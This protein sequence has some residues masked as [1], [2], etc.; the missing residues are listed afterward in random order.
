MNPETSTDPS[1]PPPPGPEAPSPRGQPAARAAFLFIVAAVVFSALCYPFR[2]PAEILARLDDWSG[3]ET[4]AGVFYATQLRSQFAFTHSVLVYKESIAQGFLLAGL[5]AWVLW[6]LATAAGTPDPSAENGPREW[7]RRASRRP[8]AWALLL[9]VYTGVSALLYSPTLY[10]SLRTFGLFGLGVFAVLAMADLRPSA[11]MV[12]KFLAAVTGAGALVAAVAVLQHLGRTGWFLPDFDD[13]RNRMGS[14]I[15][16]NTGVSAWLMFPLCFALFFAVTA[17]RVSW[18]VL[19]GLVVVMCVFVLIA[20]QSRAAWILAAIVLPAYGVALARIL[21]LR[22]TARGW[23]AAALLLLAVVA[24]QVVAPRL[25]PLARHAV[26]LSQRLEKD[27]SPGQL[28]RETRLRILVV[29][30]PLALQSPVIGHGFGAFQFVY[31]KAQGDYFRSHPDTRLGMT[32]KR[33]DL[34]HND[35]LQMLVEGGL[36]GLALC[37]IPLALLARRVRELWAADGVARDRAMRAA[38]L[39]P[40]LA[41]AAHACV[42]FPFHIAPVGYLAAAC[43]G[44]LGGMGAVKPGPVRPSAAGE[45]AAPRTRA[46]TV[47]VAGGLLLLYVPVAGVFVLRDFMGDVLCSDGNN[48]LHTARALPEQQVGAQVDAFL[49]ARERF[50]RATRVNQ[51]NASAYEGMVQVF[52]NLGGIGYRLWREAVAQNDPQKAEQWRRDAAANAEQAVYWAEAQY[53]KVRELR[54]HYTF[55][56]IGVAY[57]LRW[58]VEPNVPNWL[59]AA[60]DAFQK[61]VEYNMADVNSQMELA[62]VLER[63]PTPDRAGA[64]RARAAIFRHDPEFAVRQYLIP[65]IQSAERGEFAEADAGMA[66]AERIAPT[67]WRVRLF[68]ADL[69]LREAL[70][71][72]ADLDGPTTSPRQRQWFEARHRLG[73]EILNRLP[74]GADGDDRVQFQRMYFAATAGDYPRALALADSLV[75]RMPDRR[76]LLVFRSMVAR[77]AGEKRETWKGAE[78]DGEYWRILWRMRLFYFADERELGAR[79]LAARAGGGA[80]IDVAEGLRAASWLKATGDWT[81]VAGIARTLR[82][83]FP[84]DPGALKLEREVRA[85]EKGSTT[86]HP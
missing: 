29:S 81:A 8:G 3:R 56:Q 85:R 22:V 80:I 13:P 51:F 46:I 44:M 20:A 54:Y 15:G 50:R 24:S 16:H 12:R 26:P 28:L 79:Q 48:W 62:D 60:R 74:A 84:L 7:L 10:T 83:F 64:D 55:H 72:P 30:L 21:G 36:I 45:P 63:L 76:D 73:L 42:D 53:E 41:A 23:L 68:R 19:S 5:C 77:R 17:R 25:N 34:A 57:Y 18:R 49:R 69:F 35:Y 43:L 6:R 67:D 33:T 47:L 52:T 32:T 75:R 66:R 38:L 86:V 82:Q 40:L 37:A 31:P 78:Q 70:W 39:F 14:L 61:A 1:A 27:F 65:V 2:L 11:A 58:R 71:P 59:I 9:L 4:A